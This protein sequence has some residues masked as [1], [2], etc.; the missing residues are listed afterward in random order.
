M[1]LRNMFKKMF[2]RNPAVSNE[3]IEVN[4]F[5]S[6]NQSVN[7]LQAADE[8]NY[9]SMFV[10]VCV[11]A[12]A[13]NAAKL[14]PKVLLGNKQGD[15]GLQ[16]MLEISPNEYMNA[17]EFLY[18]VVTCW[19]TDNNAFIFI[20]R[21][22]DNGKIEGLYPVNYSS[23]EF[24]EHAG[25]LFVRFTFMTGFR[26]TVAYTDLCHLRRFFGPNDLFGESNEE[27]LKQQVGLINIVNK[28][29]AAAVNTNNMLKGIIKMNLN[30]KNED[31]KA[32]QEQFV[33]DYM[34]ITNSGGIAALDS[35]MDYIE[36]KNN[37]VTA[38]DNQMKVLRND[39]M[40]YF[41]ISEN[42]L[43]AK[44]TEDEWNAF[45]ES[46]IEPIAIRLGLELTRKIFTERELAFGNR[47]VLEANRLQYMSSTSKIN[48]LK[49]MMPFGIFDV[50][51]GREIF[52][53]AP[54]PEGKGKRR[55]QSLNFVN[56]DTADEYQ[57]DGI[58]KAEPNKQNN[59]GKGGEEGEQE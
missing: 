8:T 47:I 23:C 40:Q 17:F 35:R 12:I 39:V 13:E 31:L 26:M 42:I 25:E 45:Y 33:K 37:S 21:N 10:R 46:V 58:G 57:L 20:K 1:D 43:L 52:N 51:E 59:D 48:L 44:Y 22:K 14:K 27:T 53:M 28:G 6:L 30:L 2:G 54:L 49:E 38:D 29:L 18:K 11:D 34:T 4:H 3:P 16:R 24:V 19:A 7:L 50:D 15:E 32:S 55:L 9:K 5:V 41:H 36:L 56:Y